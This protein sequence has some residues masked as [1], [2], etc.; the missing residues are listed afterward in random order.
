MSDFDPDLAT[1]LIA[2]VSP[3]HRAGGDL[4]LTIHGEL[5]D[6]IE[7]ACEEN[8]KLKSVADAAVAWRS[9]MCDA[10]NE[11]GDGYTYHGHDCPTNECMRGL[12][13][14]VDAIGDK[15]CS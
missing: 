1:R 12:V 8:A 14:V 2:M 11:C 10:P 3:R 6:Q 15:P 9:A 5:A 4:G 13:D 7:A